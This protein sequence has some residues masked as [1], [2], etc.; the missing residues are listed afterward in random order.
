MLKR[1]NLLAILV[2]IGGLSLP[3]HAAVDLPDPVRASVPDLR[4]LGSGRMTW[5]GLHLYDVALWTP[6][7]SFAFSDAF[8]LA[9]R[10][11]R[12]LRGERIAQRS[13]AEIERLGVADAAQVA[14]WEAEML[15]IFPDVDAGEKL[16]GVYLP[17]QGAEF[18]YQNQFI[19]R[20]ADP[21]FGRAFF[22]IWL[23]P[24]TR[25]PELRE[26]L[27]GQR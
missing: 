19:G 26:R 4:L 22:S 15:R 23:D 8:A 21:E 12:N 13:A 1:R 16:T 9:I 27:T 20:I 11:T 24:R 7:R 2:T 17:S 18:F 5:F 25:E 3:V 10:Y 6:R 14:R